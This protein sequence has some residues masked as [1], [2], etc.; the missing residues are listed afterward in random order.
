MPGQ[1]V[2]ASTQSFLILPLI[3]AHAH[4]SNHCQIN[5]RSH[6]DEIGL[7]VREEFTDVEEASSNRCDWL[8]PTRYGSRPIKPISLDFKLDRSAVGCV[9]EVDR[10]L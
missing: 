1:R 9:D 5:T 3:Q 10:G 7:F 8:P 2:G 6:L 4:R